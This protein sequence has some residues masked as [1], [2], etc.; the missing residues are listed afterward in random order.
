MYPAIEPKQ[1]SGK[2]ALIAPD[3]ENVSSVVDFWRWAYSEL[4]GNAERGNLAEYIVA[5][6]P[7]RAFV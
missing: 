5:C 1:L 4:I 2:E 7:G 3:G 6:A